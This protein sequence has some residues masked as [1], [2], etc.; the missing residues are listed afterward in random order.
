M[1]ALAGTA[2]RKLVPFIWRACIRTNHTNYNSISSYTST[3]SKA[4]IV[5]MV[6]KIIVYYLLKI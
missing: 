1:L 5:V 6:E 3:R 2:R 4:K